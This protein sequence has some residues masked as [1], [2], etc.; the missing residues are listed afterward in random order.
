MMS[1]RNVSLALVVLALFVGL[2]MITNICSPVISPPVV[3]QEPAPV[4]D[5]WN[6]SVT[7]KKDAPIYSEEEIR[8]IF[9]PVLKDEL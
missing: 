9:K 5:P 4:Y 8:E 3:A 7:I 1:K 6:Y 2:W